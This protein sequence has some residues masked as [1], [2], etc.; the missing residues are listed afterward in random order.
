MS[1]KTP[2]QRELLIRIDERTKN[3]EESFKEHKDYHLK[4]RFAWF[5]AM[6]SAIAALVV[7]ISK[8]LLGR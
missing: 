8:S 5:S 2:T 7:A 4:L 6:A 1:D 3:L